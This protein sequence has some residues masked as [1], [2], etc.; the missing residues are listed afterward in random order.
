MGK[1]N[2]VTKTA[3][4]MKSEPEI[5][6][7]L[8][9]ET[10][11]SPS[12]AELV[13]YEKAKEI[14][15]FCFIASPYYPTAAMMRGMQENLPNLIKSYP[16]NNPL[17]SQKNLAA[18]LHVNPENLIIGNGATEL[19]VLINTLLIDR[20]GVPVPTFGE[21][22]EKL[23]D[24]R[25]AEL[26]ALDPE[27][28]YQLR[29][30]DYLAWVRSRNLRA[31]LVINPGNPTGQLFS[32]E[33]MVDFLEQTKDLELVLIDESFI[34]FAGESVPSLLPIA[35]QF[36]NLLIV[37]SVS[38]H[39]GVPGLRIGYCYSGNLYLLNRL[40]RFIP[41]WNLNSVA[42]YFLSLL[43]STDADYQEARKRLIG[44]VRWL[45]EALKSTPGIEPYPTGANFVLCKVTSG[46]TAAEVQ[47]RLL[48]E[49]LM[50]VRDCSNKIGMDRF[51]I[52]VASQGRDK[53]SRL[54]DALR[55]LA[56]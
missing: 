26:Y 40:R 51:H 24:Y 18:V 11:H 46:L 19:I 5:R 1:E 16:S 7:H 49:H 41:T 53:D 54:V 21:Y 50:Y 38:K 30:A 20:I 28:H 9:Y 6:R 27:Q 31:L 25:D 42:H 34:D 56:P 29:L 48:T 45:Y 22:I 2:D 55:A 35:D 33:E 52:R 37:R 17:T 13:G 44:D 4:S 39:C 47:A 3:G 15:D 43:P 36:S 8:F 32:R 12:L 10:S 23:R 14:I